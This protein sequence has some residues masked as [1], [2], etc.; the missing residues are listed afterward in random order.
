MKD[1]FLVEKQRNMQL[2]L[3]SGQAF[4]AALDDPSFAPNVGPNSNMLK[5]IINPEDDKSLLALIER[6]AETGKATLLEKLLGAGDADQWIS[7]D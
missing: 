3:K 7:H 2:R 1:N 4:M 6:I 5:E